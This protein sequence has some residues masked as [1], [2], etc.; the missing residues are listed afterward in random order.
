MK[1]LRLAISFL[2]MALGAA[3]FAQAENPQIRKEIEAVYLKWDMLVAK[4][5]TKGL[6]A[7]I[8]K[9][10]AMTDIEGQTHY[11]PEVKKEFE[12]MFKGVRNQKSTITI[13]EIQEQGSEVVAWVSMKI[14]FQQKQ[15][16]KWTP[17]SFTGRYAETLRRIGGQWKFVA[18]QELPKT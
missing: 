3:A 2:A 14:S 12:S 13:H 15:G 6:L 5:D 18:A 16:N 10:C 11:Y 17:V 1:T 9:S 7:M 4:G 8:D